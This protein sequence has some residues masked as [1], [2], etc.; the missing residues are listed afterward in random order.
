MSPLP[1]PS[2][3]A[4]M[5]KEWTSPPSRF[6]RVVAAAWLWALLK[7]TYS[8]ETGVV[9]FENFQ[10]LITQQT[11]RILTEKGAQAV[12]FRLETKDGKVSLKAK[13]VR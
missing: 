5:E 7:L 10:K 1:S 3:S 4:V 9:K 2:I 12:D 8:G 6:A 11:T 13:A